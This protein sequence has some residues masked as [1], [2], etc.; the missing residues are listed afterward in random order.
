MQQ[1][2]QRV[3]LPKVTIIGIPID[4]EP[5]KRFDQE[6]GKSMENWSVSN[7][8]YSKCVLRRVQ[9][10]SHVGKVELS[11]PCSIAAF[12]IW[13]WVSQPTTCA[14]AALWIP[15]FL[16]RSG[17][18]LLFQAVHLTDHRIVQGGSSEI[19]HASTEWILKT[20]QRIKRRQWNKCFGSKTQHP[21]KHLARSSQCTA[22]V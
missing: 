5:G 12:T 2:G 15:D 21:L 8:S 20:K 9:N 11:K 6:L 4:Q 18:S 3:K 22:S 10:R 17:C 13:I 19:N 14:E 1:E 7:P 16:V